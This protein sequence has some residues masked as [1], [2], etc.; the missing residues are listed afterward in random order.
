MLVRRSLCQAEPTSRLVVY[1]QIQRGNI[2]AM[3]RNVERACIFGGSVQTKYGNHFSQQFVYASSADPALQRGTGC[4]GDSVN[5]PV[6]ATFEQVY[7]HDYY[8]VVWNDQFYDDPKVAGCTKECGAPW[9]HSKAWWRERCGR[10]LCAASDHALMAGR[11]QQ[12]TATNVRR[13]YARV[14]QR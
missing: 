2:P 12:K 7:D 13:Q 4:A 3:R 8:F 11:R 1:L 10:R 14:R 5:D 6:G 9:G